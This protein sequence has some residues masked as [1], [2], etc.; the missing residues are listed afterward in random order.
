ML[1]SELIDRSL[2]QWLYPAGVSRPSYDVLASAI[3]ASTATI[4]LEGRI[5]VPRDSVLELESELILTESVVASTVTAN[6][7]GY[8]DTTAATHASGTRVYLDPRYTRKT[9]FN[10][11][12][13][14]IG[15]LYPTIYR[16]V[17][18]A[19]LLFSLQDAVALPTG[20]LELL[21]ATVQ[22]QYSA[23]VRYNPLRQG[24]DYVVLSEFT[25]P[26]AQFLSGGSEGDTLTL[27]CAKDFTLPTTEADDL[28][29]VC[30]IS[31]TLAPHLAAA[32]AGT[33]LQAQELP[34]AVLDQIRRLLAQQG[35]QVG[36]ALNVG[37]ALKSMFEQKVAAERRRLRVLDPAEFVIER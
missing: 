20:T 11:L 18:D 14:V 35:V 15:D 2:N 9:L 37:Q 26:K 34:R 8:L 32:V 23:Y 29:T 6:E 19:T 12:C 21:R 3:D 16:R 31:S 30:G 17:V 22:D 1:V 33:M 28:T 7:R 27:V 24:V 5:T 25:P 13:S 10:V 4:P 36:A